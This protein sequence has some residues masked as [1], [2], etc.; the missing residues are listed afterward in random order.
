MHAAQKRP[1]VDKAPKQYAIKVVPQRQLAD[2]K[3]DFIMSNGMLRTVIKDE[4][5]QMRMGI[6]AAQI[7][8]AQHPRYHPP[9]A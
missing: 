8:L 7:R 3:T 2:A 9:G 1:V 6:E 5:A 4:I